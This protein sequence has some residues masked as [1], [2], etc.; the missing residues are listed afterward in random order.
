MHGYFDPC[1]ATQS[2]GKASIKILISKNPNLKLENS[3]SESHYHAPLPHTVA[4]AIENG[5]N[6]TN[7]NASH[8]H[9]RSAYMVKNFSGIY[10]GHH[11]DSSTW[12]HVDTDTC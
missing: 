12:I 1:M 5:E 6:N 3:M 7:K 10:S 2:L 11:A 4:K 8:F 9:R